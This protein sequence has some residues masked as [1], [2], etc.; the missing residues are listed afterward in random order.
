MLEKMA[1]NKAE[2]Y[3]K[4][5]EAFGQVLKE[6]PAED[7]SNKEKIA[8]LLRFAST[9]SGNDEQTVGL[10]QYIERIKDGQDKIYFLT[11]ESYAQVKN[12]PRLEV[13]RK[14]KKASKSYCSPTVLMSG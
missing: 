2:D 10:S 3:Q 8:G 1:K 12:N 14:K 9:L 13:S 11:G 6:G 5:W 7:F 4:F